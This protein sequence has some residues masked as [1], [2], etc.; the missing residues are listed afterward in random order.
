MPGPHVAH[1]LGQYA[2]F[3][4]RWHGM[5]VP[6]TGEQARSA[7]LDRLQG[8]V[9]PYSDLETRVLPGRIEDYQ[10]GELDRWCTAGTLMWQGHERLGA[11]DGAISIFRPE[12]LPRLVRIRGLRPGAA[13][14]SLRNLLA[15]HDFCEF[16]WIAKNLGGFPP[17]IL[18]ALWD[19]VWAGEL[20]NTRLTPLLSLMSQRARRTRSGRYHQQRARSGRRLPEAIPGAAGQWYLLTGPR[21]RAAPPAERDHALMRQ[22]LDRWGIIGQRC[23]QAEG[24]TGG[25]SRFANIL[26]EF[27]ERGGVERGLFVEDLGASQFGRIDALDLLDRSARDTPAWIIAAA[28]PANP[29]GRLAPWPKSTNPRLTPQRV[30]GAR[31][32]LSDEGPIGFLS[33]A[34]CDL[35]TFDTPARCLRKRKSDLSCVLAR[36]AR[37]GQPMLLRKVDGQF[38]AVS[39]L[40]ADLKS[41][42]FKESRGGYICRT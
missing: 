2:R 41:A 15:E 35:I 25:L 23:L 29:C 31:I 19:L 8:Y 38:P 34:G 10:F 33:A 5:E 20:S 11:S 40:S 13:Y 24:V 37:P 18:K 42:G 26:D 1:D 17:Q 14:V 36:A 32:V 3:L 39:P 21:F 4:Y 28:D 22:M 16:D 9:L 30:A 7:A 27:V 6:G 12:Q